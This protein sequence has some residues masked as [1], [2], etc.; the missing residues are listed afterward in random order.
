M[1]N[2]KVTSPLFD[3]GLNQGG[4]SSD[5]L[6]RGVPFQITILCEM[7]CAIIQFVELAVIFVSKMH[8]LRQI[9]C[10]RI[11]HLQIRLHPSKTTLSLTIPNYLYY[12]FFNLFF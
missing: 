3:N 1:Q 12:Y 2:H 7:E 9:I 11:E 8:I 4:A 6:S 10:F 5:H